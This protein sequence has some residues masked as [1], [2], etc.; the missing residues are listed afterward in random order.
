MKNTV[1]LDLKIQSSRI[2]KKIQVKSVIK[3]KKKKFKLIFIRITM[4]YIR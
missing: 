2:K 4:N 3:I 1:K